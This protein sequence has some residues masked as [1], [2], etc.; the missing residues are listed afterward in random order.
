MAAAEV[1]ADQRRLELAR[2]ELRHVLDLDPDE[3]V[4]ADTLDPDVWSHDVSVEEVV[5]RAAEQRREA[6]A[7]R[8]LSRRMRVTEDRLFAEAVPPLFVSFEYEM[9]GNDQRN[10]SIGVGAQI[11]LPFWWTAQGERGIARAESVAASDAAERTDRSIAREA[12]GALRAIELAVSE[13]R[14][15]DRDAVPAAEQAL[16]LIDELLAAG[17]VEIFRA[18]TARRDVFELRA[19]RVEALRD[20]WIARTELERA[21]GGAIQ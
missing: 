20:A 7:W 16:S 11:G 5:A 13:L 6:G 12:A 10:Q 3:H 19:R 14:Q 1:N 17:S 21:I 9:Q 8:S 15:L 18:L 2:N 4:V